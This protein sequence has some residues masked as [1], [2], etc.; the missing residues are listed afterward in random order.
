MIFDRALLQSS[1]KLFADDIAL[2]SLAVRSLARSSISEL[3]Q[4]ISCL[5]KIPIFL[6]KADIL[7]TRNVRTNTIPDDCSLAALLLFGGALTAFAAGAAV[8]IA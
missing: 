2:G 7:E 1:A 8:L 6:V 5:S 3:T 4:R